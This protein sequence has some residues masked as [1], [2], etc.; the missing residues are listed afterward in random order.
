[1]RS[2][3]KD[4]GPQTTETEKMMEHLWRVGSFVCYPILAMVFIFVTATSMPERKEHVVYFFLGGLVTLVVAA[5]GASIGSTVVLLVGM[6]MYTVIGLWFS[7][8]AKK[9]LLADQDD[10]GSE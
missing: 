2:T 1:M 6:V 7:W 8:Y 9:H 4:T 3:I 10:L 5:I